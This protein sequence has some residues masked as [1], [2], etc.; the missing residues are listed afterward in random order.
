[1]LHVSNIVVVFI[2]VMEILLRG[3]HE[4]D[5]YGLESRCFIHKFG[6]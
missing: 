6:C 5:F 1:M 2:M 3:T 4:A